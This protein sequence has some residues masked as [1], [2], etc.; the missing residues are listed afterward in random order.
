MKIIFL[1]VTIILF[2]NLFGQTTHFLVQVRDEF[3]GTNHLMISDKDSVFVKEK[4][5]V[6]LS[7]DT[8]IEY[9]VR[10]APIVLGRSSYEDFIQNKDSLINY[11]HNWILSSIS[12]DYTI[13]NYEIES[14]NGVAKSVVFYYY[15][16]SMSG[17]LPDKL[18]LTDGYYNLSLFSNGKALKS[19]PILINNKVVIQ[20]NN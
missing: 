5:T 12:P 17:L 2:S 9:E 8:L 14:E 13:L 11:Y 3:I 19:L 18:M 1:I 16:T 15:E 7:N 4:I 20:L 6:D 10:G